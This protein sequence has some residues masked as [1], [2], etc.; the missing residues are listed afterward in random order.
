MASSS[1]DKPGSLENQLRSM[2]L[3][4]VSI[5]DGQVGP[6][7]PTSPRGPRHQNRRQFARNGNHYSQRPPQSPQYQS[8]QQDQ[9][10]AYESSFPTIGGAKNHAQKGK[11]NRNGSAHLATDGMS[12]SAQS[13]QAPQQSRGGLQR[14]HPSPRQ[15][16]GHFFP[17]QGHP[18]QAPKILQRP[19]QRQVPQHGPP[20]SPQ[21]AQYQ[22]LTLYNRPNHYPE[23][24]MI[25]VDYLDRLAAHEIPKV[26]ISF[27]ELEEKEAFRKLLEGICKEAV[28]QGYSGDMETISLVG[29]GSLASG[30][31]TPG[32]DMDL[33]IV[34]KWKD[35][36]D[37]QKIEIHRDIPRL[38]EKA[39][40]ECK[41]GGRLLTRTRVPI[42][43]VCQQPN[44]ELYEALYEERKKWDELSEEEQYPQAP[45][46]QESPTADSTPDT[47]EAVEDAK[48]QSP[49]SFEDASSS[50]ELVDT[51][52]A[53][54]E[55]S[56]KASRP[57]NP[58]LPT[59]PA[60]KDNPSQDSKKDSKDHKPPDR[61]HDR[62]WLRE[63]VLGPLDFPKSGVGIQCDINFSNPLGIHNT[64]LLRCYSLCDPRVRPLVLFVKSWAKRRKINSSYSGTLSS[65]G[66]VLMV[67]HYLVNIAQPP[68]CPNL[69]LCW[70]PPT[71]LKGLEAMFKETSIAGYTVRFWR[72]E[73]E[74]LREAQAGHLTNNRESL[75]SLLR[76]FFQYFAT[77]SQGY[78]PRLPAFHWMHEALSLRTPG[79]IKLKQDKGWTA[80]RKTMVEGKEV[81]QRYLFA[82][83]DPFELDHNV[84]RTVTHNGIVAIRDEFRRAWR[85]LGQVGRGQA[86]EGGVFDEVVEV[87]REDGPGTAL[88][89]GVGERE[90]EKVGETTGENTDKDA[91]V[92]ALADAEGS[93]VHDTVGGDTEQQQQADERE[94]LS[95]ATA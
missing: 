78:G 56:K 48:E 15:Q 39:V 52:L 85:I 32:S 9:S 4:N 45:A 51:L 38:L 21:Q 54:A 13:F 23:N 3:Q 86:V 95:A 8:N 73:D 89:Q 27:P 29:F 47:K 59:S 22:N 25:Q 81:R 20:P 92:K 68:V 72:N 94:K 63:K 19:Q 5:S 83:E 43:K 1:T 61:P 12:N 66:W 10:S 76:G 79:G 82:I 6:N 58:K 7:P 80:A 31:A 70:R 28:S 77:P 17:N 42:L 24:P 46:P 93:A 69:Q 87:V 34:P 84:A 60:S 65:Y 30:F 55:P 75:G 26:E 57:R 40:L 2:I 71:D 88:E 37:D 90:K 33:A 62:P 64:H 67:L 35:H 14:Q 50:F 18:M 53:N 74:I 44:G 91:A 16:P 41:M 11:G 49:I 36:V